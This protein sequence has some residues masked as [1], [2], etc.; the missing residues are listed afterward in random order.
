MTTIEDSLFNVFPRHS[1][2]NNS[3]RSLTKSELL[4]LPSQK[5]YNTPYYYKTRASSDILQSQPTR[6]KTS[7]PEGL[8]LYSI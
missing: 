4:C 8:R 6:L 2:N 3:L 1:T 5:T 7:C